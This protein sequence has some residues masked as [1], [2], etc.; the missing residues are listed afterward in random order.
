MTDARPL[1]PEDRSAWQPLW[2]DYLAFYRKPLDLAITDAAFRRLAHEQDGMFGLLASDQDLAIGSAHVV[3]HPSTWT[4]TSYA[5]LEDLF[6][7]R[8]A[9][10]SGAA[11]AL[12]E[13]V[14]VRA[15][16]VRDGTGLLAHP[17]VQRPGRRPAAA[18]APGLPAHRKTIHRLLDF[19][20]ETTDED[21][22][23]QLH[24]FLQSSCTPPPHRTV[25]GW[26]SR[27]ASV[28]STSSA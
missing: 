23:R 18:R 12:I 14:C 6:V 1:R 26:L 9:R 13:A 19:E 7:A 2:D 17:G 4:T 16:H 21:R 27:R 8:G 22:E 3:T 28:I 20:Y 5:Y 25:C 10:G 15:R 24:P 11:Q